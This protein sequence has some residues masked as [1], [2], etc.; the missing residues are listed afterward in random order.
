MEIRSLLSAQ[1]RQL[2]IAED[3]AYFIDYLKCPK[4]HL[5]SDREF[6]LPFLTAILKELAKN[7]ENEIRK[8]N[9]EFPKTPTK[10]RVI[11]LDKNSNLPR[12]SKISEDG[13]ETIDLFQRLYQPLMEIK[14]SQLWP[15]PDDYWRMMVKFFGREERFLKSTLTLCPDKQ[16]LALAD[17]NTLLFTPRDLD[18][19]IKEFSETNPL[20]ETGGQRFAKDFGIILYTSTDFTN[21]KRV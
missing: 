9:G 3:P 10:S 15:H 13:L 20:N 21:F 19:R 1:D 16:I 5:I 6:Y 7:P 18:E 4:A 14:N 11:Y 17:K 8:E 12:I 2:Q